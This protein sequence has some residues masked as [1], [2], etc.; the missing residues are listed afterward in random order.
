MARREYEAWFLAAIESL[1]GQRR[2][3]PEA[4]YSQDPEHVGGAKRAVSLFMPSGTPYS[5]TADQPALSALF[6]LGMAYRRASSFRKLVKELCR[7]L[8]ELGQEPVIPSDWST[9]EA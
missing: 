6:D 9:E 1:R 5:E 2:I 7:L 4:A 3:H 8:A